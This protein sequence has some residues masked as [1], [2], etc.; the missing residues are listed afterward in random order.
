MERK[1]AGDDPRRADDGV[2]LNM[3]NLPIPQAAKIVLGDIMGFD[4]IIDPKLEGPL[5]SIRRGR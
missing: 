3:V 4:F 5:P 2:T 1:L